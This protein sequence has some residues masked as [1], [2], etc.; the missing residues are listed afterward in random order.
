M[1]IMW[2][3]CMIG[4]SDSVR[5]RTCM[6]M[7]GETSNSSRFCRRGS[8]CLSLPEVSL[9]R[10]SKGTEEMKA[11]AERS[12]EERVKVRESMSFEVRL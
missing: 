7:I 11:S 1:R 6:P 12:W 3:N 2:G 4:L 8:A 5:I 10:R 9:S